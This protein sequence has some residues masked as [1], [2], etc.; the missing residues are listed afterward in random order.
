MIRGTRQK[1]FETR[2]S[3]VNALGTEIISVENW[4]NHRVRINSQTRALWPYCTVCWE[5]LCLGAPMPIEPFFDSSWNYESD[6]WR[7]DNGIGNHGMGILSTGGNVEWK[8]HLRLCFWHQNGHEQPNVC[9]MIAKVDLG[10][11]C[12]WSNLRGVLYQHRC[13]QHANE[14]TAHYKPQLTIWQGYLSPDLQ[15]TRCCE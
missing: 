13:T 2:F 1:E 12:L 8:V 14:S 11:S 4:D 15:R 10:V 6:I 5:L 3:N 9:S 7:A